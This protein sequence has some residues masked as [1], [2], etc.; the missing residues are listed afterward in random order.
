MMR[1]YKI[2]QLMLDTAY[3]RVWSESSDLQI[4]RP[5][6]ARRIEDDET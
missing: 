1:R 6:V 5:D 2:E 4:F 3:V